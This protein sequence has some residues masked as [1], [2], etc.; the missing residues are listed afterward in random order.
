MPLIQN[1]QPVSGRAGNGGGAP[2][3]HPVNNQEGQESG[4][5]GGDGESATTGWVEK[6]IWQCE[7]EGFERY[8][9]HRIVMKTAQFKSLTS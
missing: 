9:H 6:L 5:L 2:T 7:T 1:L 4:V 8:L 3:F